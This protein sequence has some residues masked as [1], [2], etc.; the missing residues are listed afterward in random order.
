MKAA[1]LHGVG[2]VRVVDVPDACLIEPTDAV[3]RVALAAV[4]GSDLW[5]Y[6]GQEAFRPG[7]RMGH[8]WLGVVEDVGREV[9]GLRRG[10][11]VLAPFA[12]SDGT[13]PPCG[14]GVFTSCVNG[15]F[16]GGANGGGQAEAVRVPFADATL[17]PVRASA[18]DELLRRLLPLTDVLSTGQH[19]CVLAG[20]RPGSAV[21]VIGDGAVGLCAVLAARRAGA[22]RITAIGRHP[23]RL[24]LARD[25]GA[26]DVVTLNATD[27][28]TL[29]APD[30]ATRN[31]TGTAALSAMD[32]VADLVGRTGGGFGA[33]AE[34]VGTQP[35][36]D[37]ALSLTRPGG[38]IG[39]VGVPNGVH[40]VDLYRFFRSNITLRAGVAPVRRYLEPLMADVLNG[41]L[42]PS[43]V[44]TVEVPL[45]E[46]AA[47]YQEMDARRA[48]KALV[49]P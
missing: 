4:C 12:F 22:A 13:C 23:D 11:V 25:F 21:A 40:A 1:V 48:I 46:V 44:F 18:D 9:T 29:N 49:R 37:L 35:A 42:D 24:A 14:E 45:A 38:T 19:A 7:D 2:D 30:I 10:D 27:V 34:C 36:L 31:A 16:W 28:V 8:E 39:S 17:V 20:V 26:T 32:A 15:G 6:R 43:A 33:V 5:P 3:V 41:T 47:G